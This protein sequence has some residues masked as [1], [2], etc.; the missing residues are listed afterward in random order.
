VIDLTGDALPC[1]ELYLTLHLGGPKKRSRMLLSES[2]F[3][4]P[5]K[6]VFT[7]T[8]RRCTFAVGPALLSIP[9]ISASAMILSADDAWWSATPRG[10]EDSRAVPPIPPPAGRSTAMLRSV[11]AE[12]AAFGVNVIA[13]AQT[14][15]ESP[16]TRFGR[17]TAPTCFRS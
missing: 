17:G 5:R 10:C 1:I 2:S 15:V 12:V 14:F 4:L 13:T 8:G 9:A 11:G 3:A 7:V 6:A 16:T